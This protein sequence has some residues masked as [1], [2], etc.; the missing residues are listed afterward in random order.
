MLMASQGRVSPTPFSVLDRCTGE[1][2]FGFANLASFRR[3]EAR[4]ESRIPC[5]CGGR[6]DSA[7]YLTDPVIFFFIA[8]GYLVE[9]AHANRRHHRR[10]QGRDDAPAAGGHRDRVGLD[11]CYRPPG[12]PDTA[13]EHEALAG[14]RSVSMEASADAAGDELRQVAAGQNLKETP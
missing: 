5:G 6:A 1:N 11:E 4:R 10:L 7:D 9:S 14:G 2:A 3:W 8:P 13:G 12:A